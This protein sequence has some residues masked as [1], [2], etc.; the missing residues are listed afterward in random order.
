[1]YIYL[2]LRSSMF[3]SV[4]EGPGKKLKWT[5]YISVCIC[6]NFP[7]LVLLKVQY[8]LFVAIDNIVALFFPTYF[9]YFHIHLPF[10]QTFVC[11]I[12]ILTHLNTLLLHTNASMATRRC[13]CCFFYDDFISKLTFCETINEWVDYQ[14]ENK[15]CQ[16]LLL[17]I[18]T[19]ICF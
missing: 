8:R 12:L 6:W 2:Q 3:V 1:M 19:R 7:R 5:F 15:N 4:Y 13:I 17:K 14:S 9:V 16:Q 18:K 10:I 11:V